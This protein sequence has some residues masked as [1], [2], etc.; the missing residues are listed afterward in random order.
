MTAFI[1]SF[2]TQQ[3]LPPWISK[4]ARAWIFLIAVDRNHFQN[5]LDSHFNVPAPDQAPYHYSALDDP[6]Y[7]ILGFVEHN[8]LSSG[9][10]GTQGW[11]TVKTNEMFWTFPARRRRIT[12]DNLAIEPEFVWLKSDMLVDNTYVMYSSREIWGDETDIAKIFFK[13]GA[14]PDDVHIDIAIDAIKHF[15]PRSK[16]HLIG[17]LHVQMAAGSAGLD[18]PALL[19]RDPGLAAFAK[20]LGDHVSL[21]IEGPG[22]APTDP[23][24][25]MALNTLKQFRDVFDM[26]L[27][28][29]RAIV[30]SRTT[31]TNIHDLVFYD[32]SK[33]EIAAMWSD[34]SKEA[35]THLY[36]LSQPLVGRSP[37]GHPDGSP[38][39]DENGID[40]DMPWTAMPVAFG[41]SFTFD[42]RFEVLGTLHTYGVGR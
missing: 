20:F 24:V 39:I 38:S 14:T 2:S 18:L 41:V 9:A 6:T 23:S 32:G 36:G 16:S 11:D 8:H 28:L 5:Y 4:N 15:D 29:Y 30:A 40:W 34:S 35:L 21:G 26:R 22:N 12:S 37:S 7:G 25:G 13:E 33:I 1:E 19:A 42:A 17:F 10:V 27:A 31:R 3:L